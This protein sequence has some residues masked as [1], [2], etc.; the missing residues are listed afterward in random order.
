MM[1]IPVTREIRAHRDEHL[2]VNSDLSSTCRCTG[3]EFTELLD[4]EQ[5]S[6]MPV[7]QQWS[8]GTTQPLPPFK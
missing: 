6:S 1:T 5:T 4:P 3:P 2:L 7:V 8:P